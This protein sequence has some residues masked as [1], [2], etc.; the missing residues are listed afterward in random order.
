MW[1]VDCAIP[2][3]VYEEAVIKGREYFH[4]DA[5]FINEIIAAHVRRVTLFTT[6]PMPIG[7]STLDRLGAGEREVLGLAYSK[8]SQDILD[9]IVS[10]D[11]AFLTV[12]RNLGVPYVT[13]RAM[14]VQLAQLSLIDHIAA[15]EAINRM[16]PYIRW[17]VFEEAIKDLSE[18]I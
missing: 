9:V 11:T 4:L 2:D 17:T 10:D 15:V 6:Q 1:S 3:A 18:T 5:E 16:K 13:P 12:A 7:D 14:I 8:Y